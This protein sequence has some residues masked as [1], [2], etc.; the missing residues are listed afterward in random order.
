LCAF[1]LPCGTC[2]KP[3]GV[4]LAV[5]EISTMDHIVQELDRAEKVVTL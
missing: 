4:E 5:G 1:I 2:V 3:Y